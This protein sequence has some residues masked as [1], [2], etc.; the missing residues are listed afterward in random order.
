M[1]Y[2]TVSV[3]VEIPRSYLPPVQQRRGNRGQSEQFF[4][5]QTLLDAY[6]SAFI[7]RTI[8]DWNALSPDLAAEVSLDRFKR[9]MSSN[10][11]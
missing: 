10:K 8:I 4:L 2:K 6:K 11:Q 7:P 3:I 5:V 9:K 1:M